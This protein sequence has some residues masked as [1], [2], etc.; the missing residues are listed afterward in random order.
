MAPRHK[1]LFAAAHLVWLVACEDDSFPLS[2]NT[3][4]CL[5]RSTEACISDFGNRSMRTCDDDG[6]GWGKCENAGGN[7]GNGGN[8][9]GGGDGGD[10]GSIAPEQAGTI[11]GSG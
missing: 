8:G 11:G 7:G 3:P 10:G 4:V 5:P 9:G 6:L 1:L 2:D